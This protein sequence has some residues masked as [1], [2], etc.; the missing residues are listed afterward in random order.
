M[1][2]LEYGSLRSYEDTIEE[3]KMITYLVEFNCSQMSSYDSAFQS[4]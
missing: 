1:E 3:V 4:D 2:N